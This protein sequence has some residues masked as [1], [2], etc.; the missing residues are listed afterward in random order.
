MNK[1]YAVFLI[2]MLTTVF[3]DAQ[4]T[5]WAD[6]EKTARTHLENL[7]AINTAQPDGNEL[8]AARYIYKVLNDYNIDWEIYQ[9][10]KNRASISAVIKG[11][12]RKKEPLMLLTHL[13][14]VSPGTAW[15]KMPFKAT[16]EDGKIYGL[17]S[18]DDKN[19]TAVYL[20][21]ITWLKKNN[22]TPERDI[23]FL[24][25]ADEE[26]GGAKGL[27]WLIN[28]EYWKNLKPGFALNEGGS[29][30][31]Q[32]GKPPVIFVEAATKMYMD[33]KVTA[34]GAAGHAAGGDDNNAVYNLSQAL[35]KI[36]KLKMP[37]DMTPLVKNFFRSIL[38]AQDED[39]KTTINI[40]LNGTPK[41]SAMAAAI[42]A[43]DPFF[44]TQLQDT[45]TPTVLTSGVESNVTAGEASAVLNCRLLPSTN[46]D[47]F[48]QKITKLF[49]GDDSILIEV[50]DKP[51]L[52]FPQPSAGTDELFAAVTKAGGAVFDNPAVLLGM[53]PASSDGEFL[54]REGVITYGIGAPVS[55]DGEG[56]PHSPDEYIEED[57]FSKQLKFF[58][59]AVL[60]FAAPRETISNFIE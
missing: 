17:G 37:Y 42:A 48:V 41:E 6:I 24:A 58:F 33:I 36:E 7:I 50:L 13:D 3:V 11:S 31:L 19:Y 14:T 40:M 8:A 56:R 55:A 52:P 34:Y 4:K 53:T 51:N 26:A 1:K 46:P 16:V 60:D 15:T 44:K 18:T 59:N 47:V 32:D 25:T 12:D 23:I 28:G 35:S 10:E 22:I 45:V 43:E 29:I 20:T 39:A 27:K 9:P 2:I 38:P 30:I 5:A 57:A 21:L 54:R 49:E